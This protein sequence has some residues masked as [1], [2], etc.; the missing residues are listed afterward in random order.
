MY[1][2]YIAGTYKHGDY[3][4]VG[5]FWED[6]IQGQGK[7]TYASGSYYEG[8]WYDGKYHGKGKYCWPDGRSYEVRY[9]AVL[10]GLY[11]YNRK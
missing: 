3:V 4:Y 8:T 11:C 10:H 6:K 2:G 1:C 7:F 9:H 5:E